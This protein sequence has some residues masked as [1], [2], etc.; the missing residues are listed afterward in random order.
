MIR[1]FHTVKQMVQWMGQTCFCPM[2]VWYSKKRYGK[3]SEKCKMI[4]HDADMYDADM[5]DALI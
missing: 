3:M 4:L 2:D 1:Y 5:Y